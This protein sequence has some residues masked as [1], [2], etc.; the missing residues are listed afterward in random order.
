M[1]TSINKPLLAATWKNEPL[2]F[3]LYATPKIDGIRIL[4]QNGIL[5]SRSFKQIKNLEIINKLTPLIPEGSDGEVFIRGKT[6]SDVSSLV[7]SKN[8]QIGNEHLQYFIFDMVTDNATQGYLERIKALPK[9]QTTDN[10]SVIS[11]IPI[12]LNSLDDLLEYE[13]KSL[14]EGYEGIMLRKGEGIYK[15]GRS[16]LKEC[17]LVKVKRFLDSEAKIVGFQP[18][19]HNE[20]EVQLNELNENFRSSKLDGKIESDTLGAFLV[21]SEFNGEIVQFKIGTGF[22]QEQR[23][24]FWDNRDSLLNTLVTFKYFEMGSKNVPRHPVFLYLRNLSDL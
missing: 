15:C 21:E 7:N 24:D 23:K 11:L 10:V 5:I 8:K 6:I 16:T 9:T 2:K 13:K 17:I 22:T 18:L 4:K 1:N 19:F 14:S 12:K 20:N 3:P